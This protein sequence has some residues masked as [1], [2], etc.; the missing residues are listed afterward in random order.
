MLF[1]K[2]KTPK[3]IKNVHDVADELGI[4]IATLWRRINDHDIPVTP[5]GTYIAE[6]DVKRLKEIQ[7]KYNTGE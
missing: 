1:G 7:E 4:S 3:N 6:E 2:K 5:K